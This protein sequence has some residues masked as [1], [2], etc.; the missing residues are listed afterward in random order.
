MKLFSEIAVDQ[1]A[2]A[3]DRIYKEVPEFGSPP[4]P[5]GQP[6]PYLINF[7]LNFDKLR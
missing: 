1:Q 3:R 6:C 4:V 2:K 5:A 7:L